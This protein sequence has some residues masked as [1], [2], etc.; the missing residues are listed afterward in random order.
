MLADSSNNSEK[1]NNILFSVNREQH[2]S[3]RRKGTAVSIC[4][5]LEFE[6]VLTGSQV[7]SSYVRSKTGSDNEGVKPIGGYLTCRNGLIFNAVS[8]INQFYF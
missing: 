6:N 2:F 8:A 7:S 1:M 3:N 5:V 4:L